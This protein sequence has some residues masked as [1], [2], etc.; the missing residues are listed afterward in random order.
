[1][2]TEIGPH[3]AEL[4]RERGLTQ[5]TAAAGLGVSQGLLSL[6]EN[7]A[8]EPGIAFLL[9]ACDYYGVSAD[10]LLGR[11][12]LSGKQA[13]EEELRALAAELRALADRVEERLDGLRPGIAGGPAE[14]EEP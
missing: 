5:R 7:G 11:E 1:M 9:R 10:E 3:M 6:Y 4:R 8:R 12:D 13:A 14:K 2:K